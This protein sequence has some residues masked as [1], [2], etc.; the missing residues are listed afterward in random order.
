IRRP[1]Q[2]RRLARGHDHRARISVVI[3]VKRGD[4]ALKR[5]FALSGERRY[6]RAAGEYRGRSKGRRKIRLVE[7]GYRAVLFPQLPY[8]PGKRVILFGERA[9][10]VEDRKNKPGVLKPLQSLP[11][12]GRLYLPGAGADPRRIGKPQR[13]A[14]D[15]AG[16]AYNVA[17]GAL[18][19]RDERAL[20]PQQ[21]IEQR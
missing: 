7:H 1:S 2:R 3:A 17:R 5:V 6:H 14:A 12:T 10:A 4:R 11:D 13:D 20:E 8:A 18:G 16:L 19:V 21:E 9:R 15:H